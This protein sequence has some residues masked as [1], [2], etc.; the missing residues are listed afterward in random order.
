MLFTGQIQASI[1]DKS[2]T[3]Y[4]LLLP[5]HTPT[6]TTTLLLQYLI[7]VMLLY[8]ILPLHLSL[9]S[10]KHK[11]PMLFIAITGVALPVKSLPN[12]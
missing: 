7:T 2:N 12:K 8:S 11:N 9:I 4:L 10:N 3:T 5:L 1:S 6:T